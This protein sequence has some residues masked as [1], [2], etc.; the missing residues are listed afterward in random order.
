MKT[1]KITVNDLF[2]K[3]RRYLIPLFQR[4]Y[5]WTREAQWE[6]LWQDI[7]YQFD[8]VRTN[9]AGKEQP[10]RKHFLG[11]VVLNQAPLGVR[12]TPASDVIDGQQRLTTLQILLLAFRDVVKGLESLLLHARLVRLTDNPGPWADEAERFKVW[13][14]N[15]F[16]DDF[17]K[18]ATAGS[19]TEV[20]KRFP[21]HREKRVWVRPALADAYLFFHDEIEKL[22]SNPEG[23]EPA[24]AEV[25]IEEQA[26]DD[27]LTAL[28]QTIQLVEIS[29]DAEDDPQIIFETL[30]ARGAPLQPSD[31]IRNYVF[32]YATRRGEPVDSL[33]EQYWRPFDEDPDDGPKSKTKRFW[34]EEER[35]GRLKRPRIELFFFHFITSRVEREIKI[36][37]IFQ[38]FRDWWNRAQEGRETAVELNRVRNSALTFRGLIR[39]ELDSRFG[40]FAA[41]LKVLDMTT[42]YPLLL[43]LAE[44]RDEMGEE[45]FN[46]IVVDLES[47]VVRRN[48]CGLTSK[49][50]NQLFQRVMR[51]SAKV[52]GSVR[53]RVRRYLSELEGESSLW[54][55]D[56][57]L[58]EV[59]LDAPLYAQ[60]GPSRTRMIL[61]ALEQTLHTSKTEQV[62]LSGDLSVEHVWPQW[63]AEGAW[64]VVP[65]D[66]PEQDRFA[67]NALYYRMIHSI[68]NL[69]LVTRQFNSSLSNRSFSEKRPAITTESV[70]RLNSWF[71]RLSNEDP[72]NKE[73]IRERAE[74][75]WE[76]ATKLWPGPDYVERG[77]SETQ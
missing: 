76:R 58:R 60:L 5:V 63:P 30:N 9:R 10:P 71:N 36:S 15:A 48:L 18:L 66:L 12:H 45:E 17:Q 37:H 7:R 28:T 65:R 72:W 68:G 64:P 8:A 22:L 53:G 20:L 49:N 44:R 51:E 73:R 38:E 46:G 54:P 70:L 13:L 56:E 69:T 67:M 43:N 40:Q 26:V 75:L 50:Y 61:E 3:S 14:T 1:D 24:P 4:G 55:T 77:S 52:D 21:V 33:Y 47:Y 42:I 11:A 35:Q 39:P 74:F 27:L 31:L 57:K 29:L 32:L 6:P 62:T 34:R 19:R 25:K 16:R 41:R 2:D 59:F 23:L